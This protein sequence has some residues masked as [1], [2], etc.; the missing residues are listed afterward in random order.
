[1]SQTTSDPR[2]IADQEVDSALLED[3][4]GW[5]RHLH[6]HPE[7]GYEEHETTAFIRSLLDEWGIPYDA[8]LPT[9]TVAHVRG[10]IPGPVLIV[11]ADIDALPIQEENEVAYAST[12]PNVMHACGHDG[13][14]AILLGLAKVLS[15]RS[16]P[17]RGEIRLLFQPAEEPADPGAPKVIEAGVLDD[18]A[19][20]VGLHLWSDVATGD[21]GLTE[22]PILAGDDRFDITITGK[23]GHAGSPHEARDALVVAAGLVSELQTLVSRRVDPLSPA[24]VTVGSLHAGDAYNVIPGEA[25]LSGTVRT[26]QPATRKLLK[27]ELV[28][29]TKGYAAAHHATAEVTVTPATPPLINNAS[30][31]GFVRPAAEAAAGPDRVIPLPPR[32]GGEDFAFY[33]ECL[34]SVFAF[35][36]ARK[37]TGLPAIPHHHPRFDIDE[38]ALAVG[39]RFFRGIVERWGDPEIPIPDLQPSQ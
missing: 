28:E 39:L 13:H 15:Q 25:R 36:G 5:R 12:R 19:A 6:A 2:S 17:L 23:G 14:T 11:R 9:A 7:L 20:A 33:S 8:P 32:M 26:L 37:E 1:M 30:A 29:L 34:P 21:I 10:D 35:V 22:G 3:M 18:A 27:A 24:A 4:R 16:D 31:L 38:E